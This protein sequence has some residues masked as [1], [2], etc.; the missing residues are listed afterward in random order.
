MVE[1]SNTLLGRTPSDMDEVE[2]IIDDTPLDS[3]SRNTGHV[4]VNCVSGSFYGICLC[5]KR[6]K[7]VSSQAAL[8]CGSCSRVWLQA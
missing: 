8:I 6:D 7:P 4:P 1:G 2:G 5:S 3:V